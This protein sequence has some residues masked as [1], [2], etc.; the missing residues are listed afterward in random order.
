MII[1]KLWGGIGN[2]LFQYVFGQYLHFRYNQEVRYDDNSYISTDKLR[3]RELDNLNVEIEMDNHCSFSKYRGVKGRTLRYLY[4]LNPRHHFIGL[5]E[6]VPTTFKEK[7]E[8]YF[9][10]YWQD[11]KYYDWLRH[12]IPPFSIKS[13]SFPKKLTEFKNMIKDTPQSVSL[14]VRRGD[15]FKP[16]FVGTFGVCTEAYY[17]MAINR[18]KEQVEDA[19]FFVFSDDLEWVKEHIEL[20]K[21]TVLIPNYDISQFSYIELMSFCKHHIISNSSFSWWGAVLNT[22]DNAIVISPKKWTNTSPKTIA[23][24]DWIKIPVTNE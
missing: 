2:Q 16:R 21:D 11:Y 3:K 4:Q 12:N 9:Q 13:K 17:Q 5:D 20:D 8:Y 10:A 7:D 23:L 15:Y 18:I 24:K 14:H 22:D 19:R 6:K 1:V